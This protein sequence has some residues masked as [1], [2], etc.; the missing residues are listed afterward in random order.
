MVETQLVHDLVLLV[1]DYKV[2]YCTATIVCLRAAR[3]VYCVNQIKP[4]LNADRAQRAFRRLDGGGL[5]E[6][7]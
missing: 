7:G 6:G 3:A 5:G 2:Q 4:R 1:Y